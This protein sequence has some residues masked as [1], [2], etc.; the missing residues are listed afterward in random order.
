MAKKQK[1]VPA[2]DRYPGVAVNRAD[3]NKDT[4]KLQK[5]RTCTLNNN[6]RNDDE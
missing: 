1:Q 6:P 2:A 4:E 3:N 5:E